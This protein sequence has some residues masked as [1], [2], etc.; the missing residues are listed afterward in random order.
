[1][2][3]AAEE[4]RL[5]AGPVSPAVAYLAMQVADG[6]V[7]QL[8][9]VAWRGV[10]AGITGPAVAYIKLRLRNRRTAR[11]PVQHVGGQGLWALSVLRHRARWLAGPPA[12]RPGTQ[13][14]AAPAHRAGCRSAWPTQRSNHRP[15]TRSHG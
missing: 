7:Y 5:L 9:P 11:W 8:W 4:E 15:T 12:T 6:P 3:G 1:M 14:P 10:H 13:S 2:G